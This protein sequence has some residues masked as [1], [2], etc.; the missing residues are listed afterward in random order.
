MKDLNQLSMLLTLELPFDSDFSYSI[1]QDWET[2]TKYTVP[3]MMSTSTIDSFL[4]QPIEPIK[5]VD[6]EY[7][8]PILS[9]LNDD[10]VLDLNL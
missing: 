10:L 9:I 8:D 6:V 7:K 1:L 3:E 2:N 5:A 4:S